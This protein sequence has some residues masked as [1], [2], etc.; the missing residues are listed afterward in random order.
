[1]SEY[2]VYLTR[3]ELLELWP[4]APHLLS[5]EKWKDLTKDEQA[6]WDKLASEN[7]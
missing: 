3:K 7:Q 5:A 4:D 6:K 2:G 1:M